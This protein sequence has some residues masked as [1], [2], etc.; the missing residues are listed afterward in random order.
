MCDLSFAELHAFAAKRR[1]AP[2]KNAVKSA[3]VAGDAVQY[4][5]AR[6]YQTLN[7][8]PY[9]RIEI[10]QSEEPARAWLRE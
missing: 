1:K 8:H 3:I 7:E 5:F 10:F 4:G 6:M 2:L 9:L